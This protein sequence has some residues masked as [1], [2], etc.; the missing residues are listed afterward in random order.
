MER[1][2][3]PKRRRV[4]S[5]SF[6]GPLSTD[7]FTED[8]DIKRN[9]E[10]HAVLKSISTAKKAWRILLDEDQ[11]LDDDTKHIE[12]R[13]DGTTYLIRADRYNAVASE[14]DDVGSVLESL[15]LGVDY[16]NSEEEGNGCLQRYLEATGWKPYDENLP[17]SRV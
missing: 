16:F 5:R 17:S 3:S 10:M 8:G 2:P 12:L 6:F 13:H 9:K 14:N 1:P 7:A 4:R 15:R 11:E